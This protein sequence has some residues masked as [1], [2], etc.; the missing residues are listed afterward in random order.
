MSEKRL[1][2]LTTEEFDELVKAEFVPLDQLHLNSKE[3]TSINGQ[4]DK[5]LQQYPQRF[6]KLHAT[7]RPKVKCTIVNDEVV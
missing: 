6:P 7:S 4:I 5:L 1:V 3:H 2:L